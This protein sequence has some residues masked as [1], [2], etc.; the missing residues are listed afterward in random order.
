MRKI[1]L[2]RHG[3]P[4]FYEGEK[5]CISRTDLPLSDLG[6]LQGVILYE[7][8]Q[9]K[10]VSGV[11]HSSLKRAEETAKLIS[12]KRETVLNF[13]ELGVGE[14]EGLSFSQI[15][16][17][18]SE[19][20]EKRGE[21]PEKYAIPMGEKLGDCLC[22]AERAFNEL[23]S[24]TT[25]DIAIVSHA[26]VNRI[27]LSRILN[28]PL[29]DFLKIPQGYGCINI[30]YEAGGKISV[31]DINVIPEAKISE[32]LCMRL[33][34][35]VGVS[36]KIE[37]HCKAVLDKGTQIAE[38]LN[39]HGKALNLNNIRCASLLHD[40][41]RKYHDHAQIAEKW[42]K[43]IG[44]AEIAEIVRCHHDIDC[45]EIS[46]KAVLYLAD[47]LISEDKEVTL[48]ERFENSRGKCTSAEAL[49]AHDVRYKKALEIQKRILEITQGEK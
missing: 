42:L 11:Y 31:E 49:N 41:A 23:I 34:K 15:K 46:E 25:G 48:E 36:E 13:E 33:L 3:E 37:N 28:K 38:L 22:R 35:A 26:G 40:I 27:L 12:E 44:F 9:N 16:S 7:Y 19:L 4:E 29:K 1:Y 6:K 5:L 2:I 14:W 47:K 24:K 30:L 17:E 39:A 21:D 18:Y 10:A 43:S 20:Y 8:F 32:A 45:T